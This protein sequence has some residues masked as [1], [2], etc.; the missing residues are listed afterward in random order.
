VT[1]ERERGREEEKERERRRERGVHGG[2]CLLDSQNKGRTSLSCCLSPADVEVSSD[3]VYLELGAVPC[4]TVTKVA[5][6][7]IPQGLLLLAG[8]Y[9]R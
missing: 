8:S 2:F 5:S 3:T 4:V 9:C 6:S 1:R 7:A